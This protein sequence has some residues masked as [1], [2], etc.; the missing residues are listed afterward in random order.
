MKVTIGETNYLP[1]EGQKSS[2][3][4]VR[5][6][7]SLENSKVAD[8]FQRTAQQPL[9]SK[10]VLETGVEKRTKK[11]TD[12]EINDFAV[13]LDQFMNETGDTEWL[14][15]R[16][17][18]KSSLVIMS[19]KPKTGK[20][21]YA[22][23]MTLA[24][25]KGLNFLGRSC[26]KT[27]I[28]IV[29]LEDPDHEVKKRFSDI[30]ID[31]DFTKIFVNRYCDFNDSTW[32]IIE[33]FCEKNSI[34]MVIVD[35]LIYAMNRREN[36]AYEVGQFGKKVKNF[37][38]K[39]KT[40]VLLIHH[41]RKNGGEDGDVIR[42]SSALHGAVDACIILQKSEER[43]VVMQ[44]SGRSVEKQEEVL[45]F[46]RHDLV[47]KS[48]GSK[49]SYKNIQIKTELIEIIKENCSDT[50]IDTIS[51]RIDKS[52]KYFRKALRELVDQD[53]VIESKKPSAEHGGRP[54]LSY[55]VNEDAFG[56]K[57]IEMVLNSKGVSGGSIE[58]EKTAENSYKDWLFEDDDL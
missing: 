40:T 41:N 21:Y 11:F 22:F 25:S 3:Q 8:L 28:L 29:N 48:L 14:I 56:N 26:Q 10:E 16:M 44:V 19:A 43:K 5:N 49:E 39:T 4:D 32:D 36:D 35:P 12:Q 54:K 52:P 46:D 27:N 33:E 47:W 2:I 51:A 42:G 9:S 1:K 58:G 53:F 24:V 55:A 18:P 38:H 20:T 6:Y 50:D 37:I 13:P 7:D 17:I 57:P 31:G 34:G 45:E 30:A 15:D 23:S